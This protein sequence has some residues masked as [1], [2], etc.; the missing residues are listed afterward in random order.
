MKKIF[1]V[2]CVVLLVTALGFGTSSARRMTAE[3][4]NE[5]YREFVQSIFYV[6]DGR[7]NTC[8]AATKTFSGHTATTSLATV[9]CDSVPKDLLVVVNP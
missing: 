8:F 7:T 6:K 3:E 2:C 5:F 4:V 9:P 1:T